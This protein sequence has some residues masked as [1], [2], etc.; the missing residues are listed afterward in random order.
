MSGL[1]RLLR[2]RRVGCLTT[3]RSNFDRA[4]GSYNTRAEAVKASKELARRVQEKQECWAWQLQNLAYQIKHFR[5]TPAEA[6]I[7]LEACQMD[8]VDLYPSEQ[9]LL[10]E[11]VWDAVKEAKMMDSV[12]TASSDDD[13]GKNKL[14]PSIFHHMI[15]AYTFQE[16]PLDHS[17]LLRD[18]MAAQAEPT[19]TTYSLLIDNLCRNQA[20]DRAMNYLHTR[21]KN[22]LVFTESLAKSLIRGFASVGRL[23][24]AENVLKLMNEENIHWG[25]ECYQAFLLGCARAGDMDGVK[26]FYK[27]C[28]QPSDVLLL[29]AVE[30]A[31][32]AKEAPELLPELL[33]FLPVQVESLTSSCRRT[34]KILLETGSREAAWD[35]VSKTRDVKEKKTELERVIKISPSVILI[36]DLLMNNDDVDLLCDSIDKLLPADPRILSKAV[37][38]IV[39]LCFFEDDTR[40]PFGRRAVAELLSRATEED[41]KLV[42]LFVG[43]SSKRKIKSAVMEEGDE[44]VLRVFEVFSS[45]GLQIEKK[46]AWDGMMKKLIPEIP[47]GSDSWTP[48]DLLDRV[49]DVKR[50]LESLSKKNSEM[51]YSNSVIWSHILQ[52]LLNRENALF[53]SV[54]AKLCKEL[55][56]VY[57]PKRYALSLGNCLMKHKDVNSYMDILETAYHNGCKTENMV[58]FYVV[59]E[60]LYVAMLRGQNQGQ[61]VEELLTEVLDQVWQKGIKLSPNL[62]DKMKKRVK[63]RGVS[64]ILSNVPVLGRNIFMRYNSISDDIESARD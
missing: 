33:N 19:N 12:T 22:H 36:K 61:P 34:V 50:T 48:T 2:P 32:K 30:E 37:I 54:A 28:G 44:A 26:F 52:S 40:I 47:Q 3:T 27:Q 1:L 64:N 23:S 45:L 29:R 55:K 10:T 60:S 16:I 35:L 58:N 20:M 38:T 24:D 21:R 53:F 7:L 9:R 57:G 39:N 59:A 63:D 17:E 42:L 18:M 46:W 41:M 43:Q 51:L 4:D 15:N 11:I 6:R 14:I 31:N 62:R 8:I 49:Y 25:K 56:V 5:S 13:L